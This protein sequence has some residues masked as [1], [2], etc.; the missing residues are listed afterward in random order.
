MTNVDGQLEIERLG[1]ELAREFGL[2]TDVIIRDVRSEF[3][4][5]SASPIQDFTPIFVRRSLRERLRATA[6]A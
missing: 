6:D 5:R 4:R 3:E 1:A 2:P